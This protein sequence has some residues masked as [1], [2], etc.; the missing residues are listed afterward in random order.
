[1]R[2]RRK[3]ESSKEREEYRQTLGARLI[4]KHGDVGVVARAAD[5]D[6]ATIW[7]WRQVGEGL[8]DVFQLALIAQA[9]N[10]SAAWLA[11]G[12][13]PRDPQLAEQGLGLSAEVEK[14]P[15][16]KE[17]IGAYCRGN[18]EDRAGMRW[19]AS[20]VQAGFLDSFGGYSGREGES[21]GRGRSDRWRGELALF[22]VAKGVRRRGA[23]SA[24]EWLQRATETGGPLEANRE[25]LFFREL[26]DGAGV[27]SARVRGDA[28]REALVVGDVVVLR[29]AGKDGVK[30]S[31]GEGVDRTNAVAQT[32][33]DVPD[34]SVWVV[35]VN[36]EEPTLRRVRYY[37]AG[38]EWH[39]MLQADNPLEPGYPRI[40][41]RQDEVTFWARVI[42]FAKEG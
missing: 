10:V 42:G 41:T 11:F 32:R 9:K 27:F 20:K 35:Q 19:A 22:S 39:V 40:V 14:N 1:M 7:S 8:P 28:M 34:D 31:R 13:G 33:V 16:L 25:H 26:G 29:A 3:R 4:E 38:A 24:P 23:P 18:E 21:G 5:S 15:G 2:K 6:P 17:V 36:G 37:S 30:L 12:Q